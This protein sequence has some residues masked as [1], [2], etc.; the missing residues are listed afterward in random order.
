MARLSPFALPLLLLALTAALLLGGSPAVNGS[1]LDSHLWRSV[2]QDPWAPQAV[3]T[4]IDSLAPPSAPSSAHTL[5]PLRSMTDAVTDAGH[6]GAPT[7]E[8]VP[9]LT[10]GLHHSMRPMQAAGPVFNMTRRTAAAPF[11]HRIQPGL[12]YR[13]RPISYTQLGSGITIRLG[14]GYLLMYEGA[15]TG[16]FNG[17]NVVEN[18]VWASGDDG[19]SWDLIRGRSLFGRSGAV[20]AVNA[21]SFVGRRGS[22]NCGDPLSD[23]LMS[24]GGA[25]LVTNNA[26]TV[27]YHSFDGETWNQRQGS[28]APGRFFSSCDIDESGH[29]FVIGGHYTDTAHP[30]D[31]LLNG[32]RRQHPSAQPSPTPHPPPRTH[33][34]RV[35]SDS[36]P[37]SPVCLCRRVGDQRPVDVQPLASHHRPRAVLC[38]RGAPGA[39]GQRTPPQARDRLR[40]RR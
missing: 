19:A 25:N 11:S 17:S 2:G 36:S 37:I 18:D 5:T 40:H 12:S 35:I 3:V 34:T 10:P 4:D 16:A 8:E 15:M 14:P 1:E 20:N 28:F 13:T 9:S 24:L 38:A 26:T 31:Y 23:I 32:Q 6:S 22:N 27:S 7:S 21:A 33:L 29:G 30:Q 39:G